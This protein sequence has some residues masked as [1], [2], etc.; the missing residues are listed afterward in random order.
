MDNNLTE[1]EAKRL[2]EVLLDKF[3]TIVKKK[4]T[5]SDHFSGTGG[6]AC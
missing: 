5:F 3:W 1:K 4:D 6:H 2:Y